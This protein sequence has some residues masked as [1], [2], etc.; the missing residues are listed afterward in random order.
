MR[1]RPPRS[2]R[3]DTRFPYPTLFRSSAA[4]NLLG[5]SLGVGHDLGAVFRGRG[6]EDFT[7]PELF[8]ALRR[9]QPIDDRLNFL[10]ADVDEWFDS[11]AEQAAP[12]QFAT[13]LLLQRRFR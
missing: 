11:A 4:A 1:L 8:A 12:C 5:D 2:T 6:Q 9:L 3:T 7:H 13:N 10:V